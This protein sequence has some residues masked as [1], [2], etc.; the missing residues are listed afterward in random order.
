MTASFPA[1]SFS[2]HSILICDHFS[3][4]SL[5]LGLCIQPIISSSPF[6]TNLHIFS[7]FFPPKN[8]LAVCPPRCLHLCSSLNVPPASAPASFNLQCCSI[9][10]SRRYKI[11]L[12]CKYGAP[13]YIS[14]DVCFLCIYSFPSHL[15]I[16]VQPRSNIT[17]MQTPLRLG[18]PRYVPFPLHTNASS[19]RCRLACRPTTMESKRI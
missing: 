18:V 1:C 17:C 14:R 12:V 5:Q 3:V 16:S 15:I 4:V 7:F 19:S 9:F 13:I 11:E 10:L 2:L 6:E 8:S